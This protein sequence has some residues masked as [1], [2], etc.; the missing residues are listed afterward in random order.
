MIETDPNP[1]YTALSEE[2][3][4]VPVPDE[5]PMETETAQ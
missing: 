3:G 2:H 4:V 5:E 1:I